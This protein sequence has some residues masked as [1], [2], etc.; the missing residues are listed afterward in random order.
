MRGE[1]MA[2]ARS[3]GA[4]TALLLSVVI[5]AP[6]LAQ[7][8][9]QKQERKVRVE[10]AVADIDDV[11]HTVV[12]SGGAKLTTNEGSMTSA[13]MRAKLA[14]DNTIETADATGGVRIDFSYKT[15]DGVERQ[16][17]GSADRGVYTSAERTV[18]LIGHVTA[19]LTEPATQRT[20]DL[21]ADEVTFWIDESRLRIKPADLVLTEAVKQ[22]Q[23][24]AA[25]K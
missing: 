18:R 24:P 8:Q 23:P 10:G 11:A 7:A 12:L 22:E 13:E 1:L 15:K 21:T 4:A 2:G 3:L 20:I 19:R 25:A 17:Q 5:A 9:P 14:K 16:I 6:V